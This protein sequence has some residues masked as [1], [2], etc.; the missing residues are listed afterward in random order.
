MNFARKLCLK[1]TEE[2]TRIPIRNAEASP[3]ERKSSSKDLVSKSK[4]NYSFPKLHHL[5][6][7]TFKIYNI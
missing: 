2:L 4:E 1:P 5:K 7:K 6:K 3:E